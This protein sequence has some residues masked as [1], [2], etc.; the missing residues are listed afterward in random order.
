MRSLSLLSFVI[1]HLELAGH[2]SPFLLRQWKLF[3]LLYEKS[4]LF[5]LALSQLSTPFSAY[6]KEPWCGVFNFPNPSCAYRKNSWSA[7]TA[8][9][10]FSICSLFSV[11]KRCCLRCPLYLIS[12]SLLPK[13][14]SNRM[15]LMHYIHMR[16]SSNWLFLGKARI[17]TDGVVANK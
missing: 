8:L 6:S 7:P 9:E 17:K 13:C 15:L 4:W 5:V 14:L 12:T 10:A 1:Y 3:L 11:A 2:L 16:V